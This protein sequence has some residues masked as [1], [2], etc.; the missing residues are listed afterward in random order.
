M[1]RRILDEY[2]IDDKVTVE[3]GKREVGA[4]VGMFIWGLSP[5]RLTRKRR[6]DGGTAVS[7]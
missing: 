7:R 4:E 6:D 1:G 3:V 5:H 2:E